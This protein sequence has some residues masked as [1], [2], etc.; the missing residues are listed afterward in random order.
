MLKTNLAPRN[1]C[2]EDGSGRKLY[3]A[4]ESE[5]FSPEVLD[6]AIA[7]LQLFGKTSH[8][9]VHLAE[10]CNSLMI[11]GRCIVFKMCGVHF[12]TVGRIAFVTF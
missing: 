6:D 3:E 8:I 7:C 11:G 12:Y 4:F 5:G 1:F 10:V 9:G 2:E